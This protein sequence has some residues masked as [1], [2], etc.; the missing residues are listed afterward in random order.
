MSGDALAADGQARLVIFP[1]LLESRLLGLFHLVVEGD[2]GVRQV[3]E[4]RVQ[5]VMKEWQPMFHT[6][7]LDARGDRLIERI[8]AGDGPNSS[9]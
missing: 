5:T 4:Q 2:D 6:A 8:V 3:A 7:E 1:D 9:R